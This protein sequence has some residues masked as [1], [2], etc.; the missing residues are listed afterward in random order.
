MIADDI[1]MVGMFGGGRDQV[2]EQ[3][4]KESDGILS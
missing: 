1:I 4:V 3:E 2:A